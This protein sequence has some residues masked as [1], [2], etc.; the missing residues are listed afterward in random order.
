MYRIHPAKRPKGIFLSQSSL[1]SNLWPSVANLEDTPALACTWTT[2]F[3]IS[4]GKIRGNFTATFPKAPRCW[5]RVESGE[6]PEKWGRG[7]LPWQP[8]ISWVSVK[9]HRVSSW[10]HVERWNTQTCTG[11]CEYYTLIHQHTMYICMYALYIYIYVCIPGASNGYS[12]EASP[13]RPSN[14]SSDLKF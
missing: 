4:G 2:I 11:K 10:K 7:F 14:F 12:F 5:L 8:R 1:Y 3:H 6:T 9:V 13:T